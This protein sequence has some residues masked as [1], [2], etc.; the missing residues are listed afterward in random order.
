MSRANRYAWLLALLAVMAA[1]CWAVAPASA[2]DRIVGPYR[3]PENLEAPPPKPA[4]PAAPPAPCL[5]IDDPR[6]C[7]LQ[8]RPD[9]RLLVFGAAWCGP[10]RTDKPQIKAAAEAAGLTCTDLNDA[11]VQ[12]I[13]VDESPKT[14]ARYSINAVPAFVLVDR[15]GTKLRH[16]TGGG[17]PGLLQELTQRAPASSSPTGLPIGTLDGGRASIERLIG[18]LRPLLGDGGTL[19]VTYT[20]AGGR[21]ASVDVAGVPIQLGNPTKLSW[22][23]SGDVLRVQLDP[24]AVAR[25][26]GFPVKLRGV[27]V[28]PDR[29]LVDVP[30]LPDGEIRVRD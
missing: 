3:I 8:P 6:G 28:S 4:A 15:D 1:L 17:W 12:L 2:G 9:V 20:A 19:S 22:T 14:A 25:V 21:P 5:T 30:W 10:C 27:K 26:K 18:G 13:D 7:L 24:P 11:D 16:L 29:I 23:L